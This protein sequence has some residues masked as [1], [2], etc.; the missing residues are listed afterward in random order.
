MRATLNEKYSLAWLQMSTIV[1]FT[2]VGSLLYILSHLTEYMQASRSRLETVCDSINT[3]SEQIF[4]TPS[5]LLNATMKSMLTSKE[6]IHRNLLAVVSILESCIAWLV[7]TYKSTYRCLLG[8]ALHTV[9]S[10]VTQIADPLQKAAQGITSFITG[11]NFVSGDWTQSLTNTQIKI[12]DWFKNDHDI[13]Q[14]I[15]NKPFQLLQTQINDT[16]SEWQP[17]T[18]Q[19]TNLQLQEQTCNTVSLLESLNNVENELSNYIIVL[20]GILL[21]SLLVCILLNIWM[22]RFRQKQVAQMRALILR[23]FRT[24]PIDEEEGSVVLDNYTLTT[25]TKTTTTTTELFPY[26]LFYF[27]S[28]PIAVYCFFVGTIGLITTFSLVHILETKSQELY[29]QFTVETQQWTLDASSQWT[30]YAMNEYQNINYWI[31]ETELNLNQHAFGVIKNT[32]ITINDTLGNVVDQVQNLIHTVLGGT[33]LE[34]PAK[35]LT[36]CLLLTKIEN[37]EKGLTWIVNHAYINI[38]RIEIPNINEMLPQEAI[39]QHIRIEDWS[40]SL[41]LRN[42]YAFYF[43]MISIWLTCLLIGISFQAVNYAGGRNK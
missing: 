4:N 25:K 29:Q 8:L 19:L 43:M 6:N 20:I 34:E 16:L 42:L 24:L 39:N 14:E 33:L 26:R 28:R 22:I 30:N 36:H 35:D 40:L 38:T 41:P 2:L 12:D 23:L 1:I 18:Y 17:P 5:I 13:I 3:T 7:Q 9:L 31:A 10:L 32:A 15:I 27:I 11:G 37:I 21:G